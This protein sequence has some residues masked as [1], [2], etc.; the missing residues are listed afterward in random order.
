MAGS[1][2]RGVWY[3]VCAVQRAAP[4]GAIHHPTGMSGFDRQVGGTF[5]GRGAGT[6]LSL[7]NRQT[8]NC[9]QAVYPRSRRLNTGEARSSDLRLMGRVRASNS[10][11]VAARTTR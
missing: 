10:Q 3:T 5:A 2:S 4:G 11:A 1:Q 9:Q 8:N 6:Q 7:N